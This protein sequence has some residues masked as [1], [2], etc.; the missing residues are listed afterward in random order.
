MACSNKDK[1][2][3]IC[4]RFTS[5]V[6][7]RN[8]NDDFVQLYN[9]YYGLDWEEGS[10]VFAPKFGCSACL[11]ALNRWSAGKQEKAKYRVPVLWK[12]QEQLHNPAQCYFCV[13]FRR[14]IGMQNRVKYQ[15]TPFASLPVEHTLNSPPKNMN[16]DILSSTGSGPELGASSMEIT[17]SSEYQPSNH[18]GISVVLVTQQYFNNM[19]RQLE[20][21]QRK[22]ELLASMLK[23]NNLLSDNVKI[24][25]KNRQSAFVAYYKTESELTY[26]PDINNLMQKMDIEY[27]RDDWRL[28]IDASAS[29]LKAALLHID[30]LHFPV[31][32]AYSRTLKETHDSMKLI[33][34]KIR[35]A[36][37]NW[38]VSGDLKVT[39]LIMGLQLGRTKNMCFLCTWISTAKIDHYSAVWENRSDHTI[40]V[41]NTIRERLI[42]PEKMLLPPLHIKMGLVTNFI[43]ALNK[44]EEA[45]RYLS[46]LFPKLSVAKLR[47]GK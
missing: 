45:F 34:T 27:N 13:N 14:G 7:R 12:N 6:N 18:A 8:R 15:A 28:F 17:T 10:G 1:F 44:E 4:G 9:K 37:H 35:Y 31:P 46:V 30:N 47:A 29:G 25:Q 33:L 2:C 38:D 11:T 23:Q 36:E 42:P 40:G 32:V 24:S 19:C 43:K 20:L 39:A 21:S 41:M 16:A 26:C 5:V 3:F 22:S